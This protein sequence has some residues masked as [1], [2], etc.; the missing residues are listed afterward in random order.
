MITSDLNSKEH[1]KK[2]RGRMSRDPGDLLRVSA[3]KAGLPSCCC[4]I[5]TLKSGGCLP[6]RSPGTG[7]GV[8]SCEVMAIREEP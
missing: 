4:A 6:P 2:S 8:T 1:H 5:H 7:T 3:R